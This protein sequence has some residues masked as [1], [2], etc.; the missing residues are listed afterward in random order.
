LS[1]QNIPNEDDPKF[2][3]ALKALRI[4]F[5]QYAL[6]GV[7]ILDYQT[8]LY[9]GLFNKNVPAISLRKNIFFTLL[10]PF[11][12]AFYVLVKLNIYFWKTLERLFIRKKQN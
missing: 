3:W 5:Y 8:E 9:F 11:A 4:L 12:F 10:R 1:S 2:K 7:V 6:E